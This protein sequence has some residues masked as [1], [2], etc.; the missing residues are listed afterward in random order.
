MR[1][2]G[3]GA[4]HRFSPL[5]APWV[6]PFAARWPPSARPWRRLERVGEPPLHIPLERIAI[7]RERQPPTERH[8]SARRAEQASGQHHSLA[9]TAPQ[10]EM[11]SP[12]QRDA[13]H[14]G[15]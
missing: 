15:P 1:G 8:D 2:T 9:E 13:H 14:T 5:F 11:E 10:L 3:N 4:P 12:D 7:D 6:I